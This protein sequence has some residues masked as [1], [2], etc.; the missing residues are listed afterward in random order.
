M[1]RLGARSY[2]LTVFFGSPFFYE[3]LQFEDV[4]VECGVLFHAAQ[5]IE[6][7]VQVDPAAERF[8]IAFRQAFPGTGV[9]PRPGELLHAHYCDP[10]GVEV[11][12]ACT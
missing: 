1:N 10:V 7:K 9:F 3:G 4:P 8:F 5:G 6:I 11:E 2:T 12:R